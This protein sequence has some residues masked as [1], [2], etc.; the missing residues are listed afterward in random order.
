MTFIN[1]YKKFT[2]KVSMILCVLPSDYLIVFTDLAIL[3]THP[4]LGR[5]KKVIVFTNQIFPPALFSTWT[6]QS[7]KRVGKCCLWLVTLLPLVK[8]GFC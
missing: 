1:P 4:A 8:V 7:R 5:G 6:L 3:S 2:A